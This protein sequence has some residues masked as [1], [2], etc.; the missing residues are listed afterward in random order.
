MPRVKTLQTRFTQGELDPLM[1]GRVDID[2]YYGAC[3]KMQGVLPIPQGGF[4]RCPGLEHVARVMRK[5]TRVT[6]GVTITAPNGGTTSNANDDNTATEVTTST[7]ISTT[8]PYVIVKYDLGSAK[9]IEMVRV[10]GARLSTGSGDDFVIQV[11]TDDVTYTTVGTSQT[12]T[13]SDLTF[14]ARV[15]DS[16]RYIRFARVGTD[17]LSTATAVIDEMSVY[18]AGAISGSRIV[19]FEFSVDQTY[20]LVF[21]DKNIAV[22][23]NGEY[24]IDIA[25]DEILEGHLSTLNW[26]QGADTLLL[27]Q[28]DMEPKALVRGSSDIDW[29]LSNISF[30]YIPKYD[31]VP[32]SSNPAAD[33]TPDAAEGTVTI[34]ASAGVFSSGDVDQYIEGNGGRARIVQF[35]STTEVVAYTEIP[36]FNDDLIGSGDWEFLEGFEDV[37]SS[38]RGWPISAVISDGRLF[39]G[40]SK[41]RPRTLWGSRVGLFF[42]FNPGSGLDDDAFSR[43]VGGGKLNK[44]LNLYDGRN[45]VV[46]TSGSEWILVREFGQKVT[47][48]EA[49]VK[50]QT[51][52]GS[53]AGLRPQE[54]EGGIYYAQRGATSLQTFVYDDTQ[55]AYSTILASLLSSHLIRTP[56]DMALRTATSTEDGS[57]ILMV[58]SD[59]TL[60][61]ALVLASQNI[62]AIVDRVTDGTFINCNTDDTDMYFIVQRNINGVDN[63]YL[64]RFNFNHFFDASTRVTSGLPTDTFT[65]LEHLEGEDCNVRADESNMINRTPAS[66]SVTIERD[67]E[68]SFEIGLNFTPTVTDLPVEVPEIGTALGNKKNISVVALRLYDTENVT[69]NGKPISFRGFGLSGS[70]SPLD[71]PPP[72]FTGVKRVNGIRGWDQN[73]QITISQNA[74]GRL[75]VLALTKK[76]NV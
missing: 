26:T 34:T 51:S 25:A 46:F 7:G 35:N 17:D 48:T 20:T 50:R 1:I 55:A 60:T 37:W 32:S 4:M 70:G 43:D 74:P 30:D 8:D 75:T 24:K 3:A 39:L 58:N 59:G 18:E 53:E 44:I 15:H 63:K 6:S 9:S 36:F 73:A 49:V 42:D 72:R 19:D 66:G 40:G 41:S 56:T 71:G 10:I 12:L 33:I 23:R 69:V 67:A 16:V 65:G 21:T 47:P 11:S 14:T 22:F 13:T 61:V 5:I 27:V 2:Q 45:L 76:V 64:E 31:F 62:T 28:E 54:L 57:Y 52:V 29:A 38:S 68:E